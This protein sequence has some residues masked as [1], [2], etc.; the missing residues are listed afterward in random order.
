MWLNL[1]RAWLAETGSVTE[2]LVGP[3]SS[4]SDVERLELELLLEAI[5]RRYGY[6]FR[7]YSP[8][9]LRRRV[10]KRMED[11]G[12]ATISA[13]QERILHDPTAME[14]LLVDVTV[15]ATAM[16]RDP[17]F[18]RTFREKVVPRLRTYPFVRIWH[19]GCSTGEEVFSMAIVLEEEGLRERARIY[20]TDL[21]EHVLARAKSGVFP[22]SKMAEYT[23]NYIQAGGRR[24]F[25]A[26]YTARYDG[27]IFAS[28][29]VSN[30][31]FSQH[32]LVTDASFSEFNVILCRNVMIYFDSDLQRRVVDL[33]HESLAM[34]GVLA[35][36]RKETLR[37]S[38]ERFEAVD[39]RER[40]YRK[41]A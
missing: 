12:L 32:D 27:A 36:G 41:I 31:V 34:F 13:L 15:H 16:F 20:A 21:D 1:R 8:A 9:S 5:Y 7:H 2:A 11:E 22:L 24:D 23:Q 14:R 26:Y 33:F 10:K 28:E 3:A 25:S 39:E 40:I 29:L 38:R 6:D 18:F 19:A 17:S 4:R 37:F 35:I 30:V